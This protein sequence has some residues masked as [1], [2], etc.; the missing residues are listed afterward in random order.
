M[1][2]RREKGKR[3]DIQNKTKRSRRKKNNGKYIIAAASVAA[4]LSASLWL[5]RNWNRGQEREKE[6]EAAA[7]NTEVHF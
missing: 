3:R 6:L 1:D 7:L 2:G 5:G 4:I